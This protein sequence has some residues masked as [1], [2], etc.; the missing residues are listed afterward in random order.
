L[1]SFS[2]EFLRQARA[3]Y[4]YSPTLAAEVRDGF[5]LNKAFEMI[6]GPHG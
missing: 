4:D 6:D 3:V 2:G 1:R 5:P